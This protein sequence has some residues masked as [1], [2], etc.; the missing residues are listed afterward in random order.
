MPGSFYFFL[1]FFFVVVVKEAMD[2]G[3]SID[4]VNGIILFKILYVYSQ[5]LSMYFKVNLN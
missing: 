5:M 4:T 1:L 3:G 2:L